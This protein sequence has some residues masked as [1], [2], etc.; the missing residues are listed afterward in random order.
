[1]DERRRGKWGRV[2]GQELGAD[3]VA[4]RIEQLAGDAKTGGIPGGRINRDTPAAG[5]CPN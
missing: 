4:G 5:P 1:M 2:D 3:L